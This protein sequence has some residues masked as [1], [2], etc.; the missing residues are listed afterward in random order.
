MTGYPYRW[1]KLRDRILGEYRS[2]TGQTDVTEE[3]LRAWLKD[4]PDHLAHSWFFPDPTDEDGSVR[5][6]TSI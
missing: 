4:K 5:G 3:R 2:E 6:L 1:R